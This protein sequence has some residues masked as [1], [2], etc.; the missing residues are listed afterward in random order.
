MKANVTRTKTSAASMLSQG[1]YCIQ[2]ID[3]QLPGPKFV[4]NVA[5][6]KGVYAEEK[7]RKYSV[8][9]N[10]KEADTSVSWKNSGR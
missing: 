6:T 7:K 1:F 10:N 8:T 2:Y 4:Q 5:T 9:R 3:K